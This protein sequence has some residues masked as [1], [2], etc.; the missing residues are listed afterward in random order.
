MDTTED[1]SKAAAPKR[2][3]KTI[4]A[5]LKVDS[6]TSG[7]LDPKSFQYC[8]DREA[9]MFQTDQIVAQTALLR[10]NLEAYV[11]DMRNRIQGELKEYIKEKDAEQFVDKL[12]QNEDWLYNEGQDSQKSEYKKRLDDLQTVGNAVLQRRHERQNRDSY[13]AALKGAIGRYQGQA[14]ST[15][16]KYAHIDA[17][18]RKKVLKECQ[19]A[20]QWL[21]QMLQKQDRLQPSDPPA[22][23]CEQIKQRQTQLE[24]MAQPIM[25]KPKPAP[26]KPEPK[27]EAPKAEAGK[28]APKTEQPKQ[29]AGGTSQSPPPSGAEANASTG[30]P[31]GTAKM[32]TS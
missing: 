16:E 12:N 27:A 18:E 22:V 17:E 11:L 14:Q 5:D 24:S 8:S 30:Q 15:E 25:S 20:D 26:P 7:G 3:K 31:G 1:K 21:M 28:E 4:R 2:V 32:D 6:Q 23:T 9:Q 10:N 13:I 29:A 19:E